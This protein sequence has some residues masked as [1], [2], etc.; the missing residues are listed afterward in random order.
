MKKIIL[1]FTLILGALLTVR[2]QN[3]PDFS[4]TDTDGVTHS[5]SE[6]L[7]AGNSIVLEFFYN[8]C[9][10]CYGS[11]AELEAIHNDYEGF[12]VE[13]WSI[14]PFDSDSVLVEFKEAH[15]L[16]YAM[17]G[18]EGGG[19]DVYEIFTDSFALEFFPTISVI[20]GDGSV[21]W[22]IW[23]YT[24]GG[25]PEWRG[26]LED[27]GL[28]EISTAAFSFTAEVETAIDASIYPNPVQS[29][30][31]LE[32]TAEGAGNLTAEIYDYHGRKIQTQQLFSGNGGRQSE[33]LDVS[34]LPTG[35]FLLKISKE[36]KISALLKFQKL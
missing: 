22:D 16:H 4:F 10:G 12:N 28:Y 29:R 7:A 32:Y 3:V 15:N 23:P 30:L 26:P 2:S 25:A 21:T 31:Q 19:W 24:P 18:I 1:T 33:V 9:I 35:Q 13:V 27:C 8:D 6:S 20:C 36:G 14:S 5:L 34:D 11:A 17:G